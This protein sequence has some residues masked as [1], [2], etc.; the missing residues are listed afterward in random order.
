M[1]SFKDFELQIPR[2]APLEYRVSFDTQKDLKAIVFLIGGFGANANMSF[3]D[4]ERE[5]VAK[6]FPVLCVQVLY[7]C[8]CARVSITK[9]YNPEPIMQEGDLKILQKVASIC[10]VSKVQDVAD[11]SSKLALIDEALGVLKAKGE[12]EEE[13]RALFHTDFDPLRG[14]YQNYG[15]LPALDHIA[16]LKD[17]LKRPEFSHLNRGGG[18]IPT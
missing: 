15:L 14:E 8:F 9:D 4:F 2:S 12:L 16:T 11:F 10:G 18:K 1:D 3:F 17:L 7:H 13:F 5:V 6:E